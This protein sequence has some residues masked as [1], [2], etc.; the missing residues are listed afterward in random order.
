MNELKERAKKII[1]VLKNEYP[2]A[3][4]SLYFSNPLELLIA[5]ILSAQCTD[6]RVNSLTP[7]LFKKYKN[8][9]DFAIADINELEKD[10]FSTGFF[11]E[12]AKNIKACCK[13]LSEKFNGEVPNTLEELTKLEGVGRK[14]ANVILSMAFNIPG[15]V[16]DTH[17][18]RVSNRLKLSEKK[19]PVKIEF[20]LM[21]IIPKNDWTAFSYI[22][23]EHGRK[24]CK[25]RSP[26]CGECRIESLC[27]FEEK[28][29]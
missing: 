7:L 29:L 11:K 4:T 6:V 15:I 9:S 21:E 3:K 16:V 2:N 12:K 19:D 13:S 8:A 28:E 1:K 27:L 17:V 18:K 26:E 20:D 25:A 24:T 22:L 10:I 23:I 14:T 5:T